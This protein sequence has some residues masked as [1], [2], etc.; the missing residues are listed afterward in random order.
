MDLMDLFSTYFLV[1]ERL[2]PIGEIE[3][4]SGNEHTRI[5]VASLCSFES[6]K[7]IILI[8]SLC[9]KALSDGLDDGLVMD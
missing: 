4:T 9:I 8:K 7:S 3:N 2:Q 5:P 6:I 1:R